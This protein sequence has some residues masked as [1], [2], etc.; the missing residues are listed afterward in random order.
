MSA[1]QADSIV[2]S[3]VKGF[4]LGPFATNCYVLTPGTMTSPGRRPCWI[5]DASWESEQLI[6]HVQSEQLTPELLILTHAHV[7]HIAGVNDVL[8]TFK[9]LPLLIH[10]SEASWLQDP[11][12]NLSDSH[13]Q[14]VTTPMATQLLRDGQVLTLGQDVWEVRHVPGH[15]PGSI[16]LVCAAAGVAVVG[17]TLFKQSIGRTDFPG[18]DHLQLLS[19]IRTKLYSLPDATHICPG[20]G[21]W[22]TV[23]AEKRSNPFVVA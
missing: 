10:S 7:D 15:T 12:L 6:A 21:P 23:G 8:R 18:G 1:S 17:D 2:A 16:A 13:G 11:V 19:S 5:V 3:R 9:G 22:T 4:A 14:A 20:H